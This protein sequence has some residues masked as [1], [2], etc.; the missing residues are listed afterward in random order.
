MF[1]LFHYTDKKGWDA[2]RSQ[3]V[4]CFKAS[5][6]NDPQRP[7]GAYFTDIEPTRENLRLL[8]QKIRVPVA[9]QEY[10]FQFRGMEGLT[11]LNGGTGR[12]KRIFYSRGDYLVS[13]EEYK[14]KLY[15]EKTTDWPGREEQP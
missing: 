4:W 5:Q 1:S 2:V 8:H 3:A 10:V 15:G 13:D 14:R 11:Q 7:S 6:P 9:K 12:D